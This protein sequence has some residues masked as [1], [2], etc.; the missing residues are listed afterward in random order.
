[1]ELKRWLL[2]V[3]KG[4]GEVK[5]KKKK[6]KTKGK[7]KKKKKKRKRKRKKKKK[8]TSQI[9]ETDVFFGV[10]VE[11]GSREDVCFNQLGERILEV[12]SSGEL[13]KKGEERRR[14]G[15]GEGERK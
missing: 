5:E 10:G 9:K 8:K 12:V 2:C 4:N 13:K 1:M 15:G 7:K 14:E 6:K 3:G 11:N